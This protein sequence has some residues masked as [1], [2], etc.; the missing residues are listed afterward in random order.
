MLGFRN[1]GTQGEAA[2]GVRRDVSD[3]TQY[4]RS[5]KAAA[6]GNELDDYSRDA[7]EHLK[8][9]VLDLAYAHLPKG[10]RVLR[11]GFSRDHMV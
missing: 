1:R 11:L 2:L 8:Q 5:F 3:A 4:M 6:N 7:L 10:E 9:G